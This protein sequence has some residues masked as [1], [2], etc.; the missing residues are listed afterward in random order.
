MKG[1]L[2]VWPLMILLVL[3]LGGQTLRWRHRL[4]VGRVLYQ[5]DRFT[6]AAYATGKTSPQQVGPYLDAMRGI[7]P[8]APAEV[9]IPLARGTLNLFLANV[10]AARRSFEEA[11]ALDP[12]PV[13]YLHL[14]LAQWLAGQREDARRS[15]G[16][17]VRLD[18]Q[19]ASRVPEAAR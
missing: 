13:G 19:L 1:R 9:R 14:G 15:F 2:L 18:P 3:A 6:A 4:F 10:D 17:A 11:L 16:T 5:V 12:R 7:D 8:L